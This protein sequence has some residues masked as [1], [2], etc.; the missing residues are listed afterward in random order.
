ML[1][2]EDCVGLAELTEEEIDAIAR[3]E[4]LPEIVAAELGNYL[5]HDPNGVPKIKR[6]ILDD[7]EQA[8]ERGEQQQVARLKLV[9]QHF[10]ATHPLNP[11]P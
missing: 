6:I 10:I 2:Y 1:T 3:H 7:I 11:A 9:L 5:V 8:R 4:H